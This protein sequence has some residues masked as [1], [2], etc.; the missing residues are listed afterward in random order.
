MVLVFGAPCRQDHSVFGECLREIC[1][2]VTTLHAS[3]TASHDEEAFNG[4]GFD[5]IDDFVSQGHDLM[6]GKTSDDFTC[7]NFRG[8]WATLSM[9]DECR[10]IFRF[11][12]CAVGDV[13][14]A[15]K[16]NN[17]SSVDAIFIGIL[18]WNETVGG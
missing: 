15:F 3:V 2:I 9:G 10:E 7:L 18:R 14:N 11:S 5:G 16:T 17:S 12:V 13:L 8:C 6:V 1:I 4:S